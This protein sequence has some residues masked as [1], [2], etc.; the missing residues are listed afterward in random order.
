MKLV[1]KEILE[2]VGN[3]VCK[4]TDLIS[5]SGSINYKREIGFNLWNFN[6]AINFLIENGYICKD[7]S[8][9]ETVLFLTDKGKKYYNTVIK[10]ELV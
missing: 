9:G 2:K 5:D 1:H 10:K 7:H 8:N 4:Y 6:L 3:K